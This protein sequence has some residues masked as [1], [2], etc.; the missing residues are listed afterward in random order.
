MP[1]VAD[2]RHATLPSAA[3]TEVSHP[4]DSD[5]RPGVSIPEVPD[6]RG[7]LRPD[8]VGLRRSVGLRSAPVDPEGYQSITGAP[9]IANGLV[10]IG[11]GGAE[12]TA[13]GYVSAYRADTGDLAWRF[14]TVPGNPDD[15]FEHADLEQAATTWTGSWWDLGGGGTAWDRLRPGTGP[16]LHR[17][18]QRHPLEPAA[19]QSR[20]RGQP[21]PLKHRRG[22]CV[23]RLRAGLASITASFCSRN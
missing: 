5:T 15:G 1:R 3:K 20:G 4:A 21:L 9:R 19:P 13:R 10:L 7:A 12:F 23:S 14:Y 18:R 8:L 17:G 16:R 11:N 2:A 6:R 22:R